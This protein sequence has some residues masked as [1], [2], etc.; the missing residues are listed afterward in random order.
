MGGYI[1]VQMGPDKNPG[2]DGTQVGGGYIWVQID[3][4]NDLGAECVDVGGRCI[5]VKIA[6]GCVPDAHAL[7]HSGFL[8]RIITH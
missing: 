7:D 6:V 8:I 5:S 3:R 2:P 1:W 4:K